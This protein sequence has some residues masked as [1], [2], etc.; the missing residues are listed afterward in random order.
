MSR[1]PFLLAVAAALFTMAPAGATAAEKAYTINTQPIPL[2]AWPAERAKTLLMVPPASTVERAQARAY[3]RVIYQT[4]EGKSTVGW[5]SSRF[6]SAVP[7]DA[8]QALTSQNQTLQ[9][10]VAQL[11]N[12]TSTSSQKEK[13]LTD[14]L[15]TLKAAYEELKSGSANYLKLKAEYTSAKSGL[16]SARQTV[17]TLTRENEKLRLYHNLQWFLAGGLVLLLGWLMGWSSTKLGKRKKQ[18][19]YL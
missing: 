19:Y 11:Q 1:F 12:D 2:R 6:L 5:I 13:E 18:G 10:Q 17:Q 7:A 15:K 16:E 9:T 8:T 4:P 3:T 14:Q